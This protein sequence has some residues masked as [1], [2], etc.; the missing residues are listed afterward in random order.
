MTASTSFVPNHSSGTFSINAIEEKKNKKKEKK[1][2]KK[3]KTY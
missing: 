3:R 2:K 1:R